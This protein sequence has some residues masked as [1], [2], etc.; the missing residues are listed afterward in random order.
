MTIS[1]AL[2]I[3]SRLCES[4]QLT[5][6]SDSDLITDKFIDLDSQ[7]VL[8]GLV[9]S[10]TRQSGLT[11]QFSK[12]AQCT[13]FESFEIPLEPNLSLIKVRNALRNQ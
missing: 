13:S 5:L 3:T 11:F 2:N 1:G 12:P 7:S 10:G 9:W 8:E 6:P 4:L